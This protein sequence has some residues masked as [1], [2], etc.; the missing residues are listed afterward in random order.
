MNRIKQVK[1]ELR[2]IEAE[3]NAE[4]IRHD[5]EMK[6]TKAEADKYADMQSQAHVPSA[7]LPSCRKHR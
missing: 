2:V 5:E 1:L 3:K 7:H 6:K 4:K